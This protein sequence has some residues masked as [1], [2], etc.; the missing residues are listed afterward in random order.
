VRGFR[1]Q[2]E[3]GLG[4]EAGIAIVIL[5]MIFDRITEGFARRV[6]PGKN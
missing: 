6:R 2:Q 4:F 1:R 5:A 3:T